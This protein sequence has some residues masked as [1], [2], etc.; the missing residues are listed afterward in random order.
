VERV[1]LVNAGTDAGV[2]SI[3]ND[4]TF[5]ALGVV[6][7]ATVL[8]QDH[9]GIDVQAL[10]GQVIAAPEL[11]R[12]I[13]AFKPD[14]LGISVLGVSY[15]TS[16]W[17]AEIGKSIGATTI[18]GNDHAIMLA[19]EILKRRDVVDYVCA[20][21]VGEFAFSAFIDFL[22][23]KRPIHSVPKLVHRTHDG[24]VC[25]ELPE[26]PT[27]RH[28][29][30]G[31]LTRFDL[32]SIPVPDRT[33]QPAAVRD[34]YLTNYLNRYGTLHQG[35]LVSGVATMNRA[36]G[37][38]RVKAPCSFCGIADLSVRFSSPAVFWSDVRA[39]QDDVGASILYE[40]FDS[41]SS[42]PRWLDLLVEGRPDDVGDPKLF[43][44]TQASETTPR[45]VEQ[46]NAL[47]VYRVNIGLESGDTRMLKILK[48]RRDSLES[49]QQACIL[50]KEAGIPIYG[51]LVLGG[52][53]ESH[54]S[55]QRTVDFAHWLTDNQMMAALEAQ[56]LYPDLGAAT[57]RWLLDP[58]L[59]HR[60]ASQ[61]AFEI[62]DTKHLA[63]M[64]SK[65][66]DT[67]QL[68]FDE[69]SRDWCRI[70]CNVSWEELLEATT[71]IRSYAEQRGTVAGSARMS[72]HHLSPH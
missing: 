52:A 61:H 2:A 9:P 62:R 1:L 44:Y 43:V 24:P 35:E 15:Q 65:Y 12:T 34:S 49:N 51:S 6:S 66:A 14:V 48:G 7:L 59:A 22:Q 63:S 67:D 41:M 5:P 11:E 60:A 21:D 58:E 18:F 38:A 27:D 42:A 26:L 40:A 19:R 56:P 30:G 37:C 4:G 57:G 47:G 71:E 46:Y 54:D 33:L 16:L 53:G 31:P 23:G 50:F 13:R 20:A 68:D 3:A 64:P 39:A 25:N 69:M 29:K 72:A 45:L 55:L 36:R 28:R 8:A 10:D 32:D 70:F 17:L